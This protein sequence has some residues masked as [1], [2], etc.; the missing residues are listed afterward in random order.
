[1]DKVNTKKTKTGM[2][3]GGKALA[4]GAGV[5]AV[6]AGA[7]YLFGKNGK[8]HQKKLKVKIEKAKVKINSNIE[9]AKKVVTPI[10]K[11]TKKI[12]EK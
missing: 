6:G 5:A 4:I 3:K 9:K 7:Y 10:Y 11:K 12:L 8:K 1:M 2:S